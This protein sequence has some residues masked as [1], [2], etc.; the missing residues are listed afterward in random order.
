LDFSG[1]VGGGGGGEHIDNSR[2]ADA[3][4]YVRSIGND[5]DYENG[6]LTREFAAAAKYLR[7]RRSGNGVIVSKTELDRIRKLQQLIKRQMR[8]NDDFEKEQG[9]L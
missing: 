1:A 8:S 4:K 7:R 3:D 6:A 2:I 5:D 9:A